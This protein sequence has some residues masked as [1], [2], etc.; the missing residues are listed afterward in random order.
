MSETHA[1]LW[2]YSARRPR[3]RFAPTPFPPRVT[4][5]PRTRSGWRLVTVDVEHLRRVHGLKPRVG[6]R[7][8]GVDLEGSGTS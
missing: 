2:V 8:L 5:H 7:L 3:L 4:V 1:A 6:A